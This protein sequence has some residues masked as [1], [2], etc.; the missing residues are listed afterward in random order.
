[1]DAMESLVKEICGDES[2]TGVETK[3]A[4]RSVPAQ[5]PPFVAPGVRP[6]SFQ[7]SST[8]RVDWNEKKI[9]DEVK[10]SVQAIFPAFF[11]VEA[12]ACHIAEVSVPLP[13]VSDSD[14]EEDEEEDLDLDEEYD[15]D[16]EED[17]D[18]SSEERME[19]LKR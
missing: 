16:D 11:E 1:M 15:V 19:A 4:E 12:K 7:I 3:L 17:S 8:S 5:A 9:S 6:V 14:E 2:K 13:H 18:D 10:K